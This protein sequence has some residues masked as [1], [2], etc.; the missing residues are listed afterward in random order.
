MLSPTAGQTIEPGSSLSVTGYVRDQS[1]NN[2]ISGVGLTIELRQGAAV[3]AS[4]TT[5]TQSD[6]FFLGTIN[7][8]SGLAD[9]PYD[10]VVTPSSGII[11]PQ[12]QSITVKKT[13]PFLSSPVPI[14]GVPWWLFL[15]ILGAA[16]AVGSGVTVY[17]KGYGLGKM[18]ECGEGGAFIPEDATTC[19]KCGVEFERDSAKGSNCQ[20][21]VPVDVK[22]GPECGVELPPGGDGIGEDGG[23]M[24]RD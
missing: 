10:V 22:Q 9:G 15:V 1:T 6:G 12:T 24:A 5:L 2:G 18:V 3:M 14:L 7:V 8:P 17:W 11:G 19:P 23:K 16:V 4:N 13:L 20:P 21:W